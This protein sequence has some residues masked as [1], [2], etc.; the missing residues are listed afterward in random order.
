MMGVGAMPEP[1]REIP[2]A[3]IGS[4]SPNTEICKHQ[5][6]NWMISVCE[7]R[8]RKVNT[9]SHHRRINPVNT[10]T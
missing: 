2:T 7:G 5:K 8:E 4:A 1:Y 3:N 9:A 10:C 6:D